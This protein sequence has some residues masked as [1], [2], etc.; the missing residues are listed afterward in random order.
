M[1]QN[2][3]GRAHRSRDQGLAS[4]TTSL[5]KIPKVEFFRNEKLNVCDVQSVY[6]RTPVQIAYVTDWKHKETECF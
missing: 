2:C 5:S 6:N 4:W 3:Q 1:P